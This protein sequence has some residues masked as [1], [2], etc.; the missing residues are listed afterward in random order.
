[1]RGSTLGFLSRVRRL[2]MGGESFFWRIRGEC[3][4]QAHPPHKKTRDVSSSIFSFRSQTSG[5]NE[6]ILFRSEFQRIPFLSCLRD[7]M[8]QNCGGGSMPFCTMCPVPFF[9]YCA[10]TPELN[11]NTVA[12]RNFVQLVTEIP[13]SRSDLGMMSS[14]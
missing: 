11:R 10:G 5:R 13:L 14:L 1:M 4:S 2:I 12:N 8:L 3:Q 6:V 9:G 7:V